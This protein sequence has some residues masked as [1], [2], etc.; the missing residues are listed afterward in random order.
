MIF[1][2]GIVSY[3]EMKC[4]IYAILALAEILETE[5]VPLK[6]LDEQK[7]NTMRSRCI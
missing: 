2:H 3:Y 1:T 5:K 6:N 4:P 7:N